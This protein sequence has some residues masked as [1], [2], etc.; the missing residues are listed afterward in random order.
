M[1]DPRRRVGLGAL[2][3]LLV[4]LVQVFAGIGAT[5]GQNQPLKWNGWFTGASVAGA[6]TL[7]LGL[8]LIISRKQET[9]EQA[10]TVTVAFGS[11]PVGQVGEGHG[12]VTPPHSPAIPFVAP[13]DAELAISMVW[14]EY[15]PFDW[16]ALLLEAKIEIK[17]RTA[18]TKY[19]MGTM[20][21]I[22]PPEDGPSGHYHD[23][24][25][26]RALHELEKKRVPRLPGIIGPNDSVSGWVHV[27]LPHQSWGGVGGFTLRIED[28]IGTQYVLR[29]ERR[30][31]R[32]PANWPPTLDNPG[33][34]TG[35][36]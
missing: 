4:T 19:T 30:G 24:E 18:K 17:N 33:P 16:R 34:P 32:K 15:Q 26:L 25:I 13:D 23:I 5:V 21:E 27:S 11:A 8:W 22:D 35:K 28:E 14:E 2:I 3:A 20:W 12:I 31:G 36:A 7:G 29:R 10:E 9:P 6:L 1:E